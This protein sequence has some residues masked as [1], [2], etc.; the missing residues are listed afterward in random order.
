MNFKYHEYVPAH[1]KKILVIVHGISEYYERYMGFIEH[2]NQMGIGVIAYDLKG[3]GYRFLPN[4]PRGYFPEKE[5]MGYHVKE[6]GR[7]LNQVRSEY[8]QD[9]Y[10]FGHSM[11]AFIVRTYLLSED[12][13]MLKGAVISGTGD[14]NILQIK[15]GK[16]VAGLISKRNEGKNISK[17]L[18]DLLFLGYNDSYPE[19]RTRV[20]WLSRDIDIQ[21]RYISD[22]KCNFMYPSKFIY[23]LLCGINNLKKY[24]VYNEYPEI[25]YLI[26]S[27]GSDPVGDYGKGVKRVVEKVKS[28]SEH[29]E[30][31][32]YK[33]GRHEM[34]NELNKA[35]VYQDVTDFL[36]KL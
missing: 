7:I 13:K 1:A 18:N 30:H 10:V 24:E 17:L 5:G 12:S 16:L 15:T 11:G 3:H 9:L 8:Q 35:E 25:P 34:L 36:L 2:L 22:E 26:F 20:E 27:G 19:K 14:P 32:I 29:V 21:Y 28:C 4:L 33:D 23:D 31:I 6:L